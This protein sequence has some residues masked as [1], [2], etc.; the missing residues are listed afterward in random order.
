MVWKDRSKM[1]KAPGPKN[2]HQPYWED[3]T[4]TNETIR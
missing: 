3:A 4:S 2:V 1:P